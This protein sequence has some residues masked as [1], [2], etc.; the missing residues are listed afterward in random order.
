VVAPLLLSQ[1][2]RRGKEEGKGIR[3]KGREGSM[4]EQRS[5]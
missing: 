1:L 4:G 2:L 5:K 3:K